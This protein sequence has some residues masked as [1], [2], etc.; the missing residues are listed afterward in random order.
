MNV[1][2]LMLRVVI[3]GL[4]IGHGAR[5]LFGWFDGPGPTAPPR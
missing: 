2:R 4:F 1:G 3:G 5:K